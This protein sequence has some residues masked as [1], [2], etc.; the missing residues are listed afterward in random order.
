M[1][2]LLRALAAQWQRLLLCTLAGLTMTVLSLHLVTP[3]YT[4]S[5]V[6]GP[7]GRSGPAAMGPRAPAL[8][9]A[10]GRGIAEQGS[11]EEVVSDFARYL[12]LLTSV[13]VA[14]R[15]SADTAVMRGLFEDAWD[16]EAGD[17]R[18]PLGIGSWTVRSLRWLA[19]YP[20]WA[21]PDAVDL[22]RLLKK[23]LAVEAVNEGPLRRLVFRHEKR[24]FA[25]LLLT[26]LH[27]A[28]EAHLRSEAGRRLKA[29]MV[30]V[31]DRLSGISNL[32]RSRQLTGMVAEQE[33]TLMMLEVGLPYAADLLE[34]PAAPALADWPNPVPLI[35]AGALAGF[36]L[37]LFVLAARHGYRRGI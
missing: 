13:P 33:E 27:A 2:E 31:N 8:S 24:S 12:A 20:G 5:M 30:H 15:L 36:G 26:R 11:A 37:G 1:G 29:E 4:V 34:P 17:W 21:P 9:P 25:L 19:G 35:P 14:E 23:E 16:P 6:V 10:A 7:P 28:T 32:D 22:S 3:R 18:P